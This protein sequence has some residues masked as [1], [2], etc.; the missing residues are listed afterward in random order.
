MIISQTGTWMQSLGQ[1]WLVLQLTNSALW[2][3]II[4]FCSSIPILLFT[5][6]GGVVADRVNKRYF[7]MFTQ[8]AAAVQA[9]VLAGLT[10]SGKVQ[11]WQVMAA[12]LTLGTINAFDVPSR[13]AFVVDMVGKE[14]L[15][16]AIALNSS[17]FNGARI[18]GPAIAGLLIAIPHIGI[19]G[20]FLL[21]SISF[22][23]VIAGLIMM[24]VPKTVSV[25]RTQSVRANLNEGLGYAKSNATVL[26]LMLTASITSIFGVSYSSLLPIFALNV[27]HVGPTGQGL[28]MMCVGI[29]AVVGSLSVASLSNYERKGVVWTIGNMLFPPMLIILAVSRFFPLTLACLLVLGFGLIVQNSMTNTLLQTLSPDALRG[30]VM[31]LYNLTFSG[32]TPFGS[33]QAGIM[34][35]AFS[36]PI[37]VGVGGIICLSR[38]VWLLLRHPEL[39]KLT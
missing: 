14:D 16:N 38:S 12:A 25:A 13:Q 35:A 5:V 7:L 15:A 39:R 23:A 11:I 36:A 10:Y 26:S 24:R 2:L 4:G 20:A 19:A 6:F 9:L 1:Q 32:M 28:M 33:L 34:A 3:G 31:G 22:L 29:G 8:G 17:I 30:R 27:L 37:A 21:N 18:F